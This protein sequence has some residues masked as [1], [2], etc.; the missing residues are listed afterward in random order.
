MPMIPTPNV[1]FK[2][3]IGYTLKKGRVIEPEMIRIVEIDA[4]HHDF[5][6]NAAWNKRGT[7]RSNFDSDDEDVDFETNEID[8]I[9]V[10]F[11]K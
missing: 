7:F 11:F 8:M 6:S 9:G 2:C 1:T 10:S 4:D 5:A 3:H